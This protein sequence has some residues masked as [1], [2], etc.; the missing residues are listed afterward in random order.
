MKIQEMKSGSIHLNKKVENPVRENFYVVRPTSGALD[1]ASQ[2][3]PPAASD[4]D[5]LVWSVVSFDKHEAGGLTYVSAELVM[6]E[7]DSLDVTG[8]CIVTDEAARRR[9]VDTSNRV[10]ES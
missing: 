1:L 7:L 9:S 5:D 3:L 2:S 8:L 6:S 10:V 4:L